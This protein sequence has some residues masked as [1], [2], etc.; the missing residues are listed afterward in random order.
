[1]KKRLLAILMALGMMCSTAVCAYAANTT[2][3]A[4]VP[5]TEATDDDVLV[6][7]PDIMPLGDLMDDP[8]IS[9]SN[10]SFTTNA[11]KTVSGYG[12]IVRVWYRNDASVGVTVY[13]QKYNS[14]KKKYEDVMHFS[15]A[16]G[17]SKWKEYTNKSTGTYRIQIYADSGKTIKGYLRAVQDK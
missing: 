2:D 8:N 15:V 1:M 3:T 6:L 11:F 13:L 12:N 5:T 7:W 10:S 4:N 14:S 17:A 9:T 16:K